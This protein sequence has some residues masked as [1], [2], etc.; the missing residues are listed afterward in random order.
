MASLYNRMKA[1]GLRRE[2]NADG[3]Y[4]VSNNTTR[5]TNTF[6]D[7][8]NRE[9]LLRQIA[10]ERVAQQ[11]AQERQQAAQQIQQANSLR[12]A[13]DYA[14]TQNDTLMNLAMGSVQRRRAQQNVANQAAQFSGQAIQNP[15]QQTANRRNSPHIENLSEQLAKLPQAQIGNTSR[16]SM[17]NMREP[18]IG[19][20]QREI[21]AIQK[22]SADRELA[23]RAARTEQFAQEHP[24]LGMAQSTLYDYVNNAMPLDIAMDKLGGN[25]NYQDYTAA[26]QLSGAALRG[27]QTG[28]REGLGLE[29]GSIAGNLV[30]GAVSTGVGLASNVPLFAAVSSGISAIPAMAKLS[31]LVSNLVRN[32]GA[33]AATTALDEASAAATGNITPSRYAGD[34]ALNAA[35]G[36]AGGAAS[37]GMNRVGANLLKNKGLMYNELARTVLAGLSSSAYS[38]GSVG[39]RQLARELGYQDGQNITPGQLVQDLITSFAFGAINF[40]LGGGAAREF[41]EGRTVNGAERMEENYFKGVSDADLKS[42]YRRMVKTMHPDNGGDA[43]EFAAMSKEYAWRM[44]NSTAGAYTRATQAAATNNQQEYAQAEAEFRDGVAELIPILQSAEPTPEMAA[45]IEV[46]NSV[47]QAPIVQEDTTA[48]S[49]DIT[50]PTTE[51]PAPSTEDQLMQ[52][53]EEAAANQTASEA[54]PD[55]REQMIE[56]APSVP[57]ENNIPGEEITNTA[58]EMPAVEETSAPAFGIEERASVFPDEAAEVYRTHAEGAEDL[59]V[60]DQN[61]HKAYQAGYDGVSLKNL[62]MDDEDFPDFYAENKDAVDEIFRAGY[63]ERVKR[64]NQIPISV[65]ENNGFIQKAETEAQPA[66]PAE[67]KPATKAKKLSVKDI[68]MAVK[69]TLSKKFGNSSISF[70]GEDGRHYVSDGSSVLVF[71][72]QVDGIQTGERNQSFERLFSDAINAALDN[73]D[74]LDISYADIHQALGNLKNSNRVDYEGIKIVSWDGRKLVSFSRTGQIAN[75][76]LFENALRAVQNPTVYYGKDAKTP[77]YIKGDNAEGVVLP[78]NSSDREQFIRQV[79]GTQEGENNGIRRPDSAGGARTGNG[80]SEGSVVPVGRATETSG[81]KGAGEER[82]VPGGSMGSDG[83]T[84]PAV[85]GLQSGRNEGTSESGSGRTGVPEQSRRVAGSGTGGEVQQE[86]SGN[87][88]RETGERDLE[89]DREQHAEGDLGDDLSPQARADVEEGVPESAATTVSERPAETQA[90]VQAERAADIPPKG[91]NFIIPEDGLKLPNGEKARYKSNIAA[92]KTLRTLMA[93]N[94][95]ATPEEQEV[96]SKYVGWGGL[97]NAFSETDTN[98]TKENKQLKE[99]LTD[100]EYKTARGSVL[101]AHYTEVGV[102]RAIYNG[103]KGMGFKGGRILEPAAGV[104]HFAGAMPTDINVQSLTMVELDT[105]TGN[106]AKYLYP[107]ADVRVQGFETANLPNDYMDLAISNVPFGNYAIFDKSYPNSVT[108]AIHNY[109]FAKSLDKVRPGG[110]VCFITSRFTMDARDPAVRKYISDRAD[111]VGAIRLPDTAFKGNAGTEVVTDIL[112]LKKRE[113]GTPYK[114]ESFLNTDYYHQNLNTW[115]QTNEYFQKHP[116]MV[117]GEASAAGTMYRNNSLT[118]KAKPGNLNKQI[119]KA[120]S[121]IKAKID[122]PVR[123]SD[124]DVMRKN[125]TELRKASS[126]TKNGSYVKENGKLYKNDNGA[127][128]EADLKAKEVEVIS[129]SIDMR[130]TARQL[131]NLQM[132]GGTQEEIDRLRRKLNADY[133]AFVKKNGPLNSQANRRV[134]SGDADS[135]F[136]FALE[137]YNADTKTA[138]KADIFSKNTVTPH[139]VVEHVDNM[140]DGLAA[141]INE[142][143]TVDIPLIARVTGKSE[144]QTTRE[145]IDQKLIFKTKDGSLQSAQQYLSGNVRAKL[146]EARALAPIDPDYKKNIDE[147]EKV[148]PKDIEPADISVKPGAT[149]VPPDLYADFA[150]EMLGSNNSGW[151]KTIEVTYVPAAGVYKVSYG[152]AGRYVKGNSYDISEYGTQDKS[153]VQIFEAALN[154]KELKV[155]YPHGKDEKA[156]LNRKAT[157]AVK[158][159]KNQIIQKFQEWMWSDE[160]RVKTYA[161]LYNDMFNN[162]AVPNYDGSKLIIDGLSSKIQLRE[163]QANAVQRII[164]SGGNT[165]LAHGTGSGKTLEMAAAAMKLRQIGAIRKPMFVVPK[166]LLGQWG[167]EFYSYFPNAKILLPGEN[168]FTPK[169]R[170]AFV[171]KITTGD[172]DAV[173]LSYEQFYMVPMSPEA[174]KAFYQNQIDDIIAAQEAARQTEGKKGFTVSALEKK[175]KSLQTKLQKLDSGKRDIDNINFESLGVDSLFVDEAHNFKNLYYTTQLQGVSDLGNQNGSERAFDLYTKV[176]YLQGVN[177][178]RGIVFGT[179]TPVMNSVVEMYSMQRYLQGDLLEQKGINHFDAWVNEFGDVQEIQKMKSGGDGYE[180]RTSL[181]RYRNLGELQQMFRGFADVVTNPP[182]LA[183]KL[184]KLRGG[185]PIVVECEPTDVQRE[186]LKELGERSERVRHSRDL[187]EDNILKIYSDGKKMS[188]TQRMIDS[189][190]PYEDG[191]KILKCVDNVLKEYKSSKSIKGT[192]LVF[193]DTGVIGSNAKDPLPLWQDIKN[194]LIAGGIP[195]KEIAFAQSGMTD[196]QKE[197]M[198]KKMNDGDTRVLIGSTK[199]MGTGLN[200]QKRLYSMHEINAPDRPGDVEQNRGRIVRQ[201]NMNKEVAIYT[202]IT[203]ETFDS[204]QWD[205]LKR[206]GAFIHQ[207]MAGDVAGR[208]VDGDGDFSMSAAEISAIASGNPLIIEQN[209]VSTKIGQLEALESEHTKQVSAARRKLSELPRR[210]EQL[211]NAISNYETDAAH[212]PDLSGD[213]FTLKIG[214]TTF[215]KRTSAGNAIIEEAKKHYNISEETQSFKVGTVGDFDLMVTNHNEGFLKGEGQYPFTI[216]MES[217]DGTIRSLTNAAALPSQ[218]LEIA[219]T[220]L[221]KNQK[222]LVRYE[223]IAKQ[224]FDRADELNQLR[225]REAEIMEILN[226]SNERGV[227]VSEEN[228]VSESRDFESTAAPVEQGISSAKTS[229]KQVP[230]LFKDKNVSWGKVNIDIGGGK[231]DLATDYLK[232]QGVTNLVFDPY[233]RSEA[234][235]SDTLNYLRGGHKADTATCANV[236]NVI[237]EEK[238]RDNVILE[239]AKA[240]KPDGRAYFMVYEGDGS[241]IGKETSSGWQNNRKTATYVREIEKYFNNVKR[242]GKLITATNPVENLPKASW[243]VSPGK[244]IRYSKDM[245]TPHPDQWTAQRVGSTD[246]KVKPLSDIINEIRHSYGINITTGHIRGSGVRGQ[247]NELNKGIRSKIANDLPTI[248]HEMGHYFDDLYGITAGNIPNAAKK[249]L[250]DNLPDEFKQK[251]PKKALPGEGM[252]EYIRRFLQNSETAAIDYPEFTK[253]FFGA[254]TPKERVQLESFAD[255][256]NAYYSLDADSAASSIRLREDGG[257]DLRTPVEKV[258][259][260]GDSAYQQWIDSNYSIKQLGKSVGSNKAYVLATN[261]A[262]SDNMAGNILTGD[263]TDADGRYIGPGLKTALNGVNLRNKREYMAFNEYLVVRH[264]PE[265]LARQ[266]RVFADDRKNNTAWCQIRQN[267]LETQYPAFSE[268]A[269]RLIQFEQDFNRVWGVGYGLIPE[270]VFDKWQ[271]YYPNHVPLNRAMEKGRARGAKR[272]YANQT[273][274]YKRAKG[275]GQDIIAPVDN[276][277]DEVVRVVNTAVRNNV[278]LELRDTALQMGVNATFMEQVPTPLVPKTFDVSGIKGQIQQAIDQSVQGGTLSLKGQQVIDDVLE[279]INDTMLQFERGKAGGNVVTV[280]VNGNP[281]FWKINDP[282]L[283]QSVTTMSG[284]KLEGLLGAY[285]TTTRFLT[286]NITGNN[287]IWSIFSNLPRDFGTLLYY[288]P[289]KNVIDLVAKIGS[290]YLNSTKNHFNMSV[291]PLYAEYL[292]MGGGHTSMYSADINLAKK[293]RKDISGSKLNNMLSMMNPIESL[294]FITDTI[295]QGPRF[296]T[297]RYMR[298][299]GYSTQDA[300]YAAMDVT[301]NFRKAGYKSRQTN[302]VIP[303][304]NAGL[305]GADKFSRYFAADDVQGRSKGKAVASRMAGLVISSAIIASLLYALNNRDKDKRKDYQQLSNYTKNS[306][307]CIPIGNGKYFAIPKPRELAVLTSAMESALE[308]YEGGNVH[309]FDEFADTAANAFLPSIVSDAVIAAV[310][311]PKAIREEEVATVLGTLGKSSI[312]SLGIVG[313]GANLWANMD[314]LGR[315]IVSQSLSGLEK[316]DQYTEKTSKMAKAVGKALN[317]S[318]QQIDYVG[319]NVLGYIWKVPTALFPVGEENVDPTLGIKNSYIKDPQYSTDLVNWAYDHK[320]KTSEKAKSAPDDG[321]KALE[322]KIADNMTSFYGRFIKVEKTDNSRDARQTVLDMIHEYRKAVDNG[323]RTTGEEQVYNLVEH[324]GDTS[325]LPS[326]MQTYVQD[327]DKEKHNLNDAQYVEYQTVYNGRYWAYAEESLSTL[328]NPTTEQQIKAVENAKKLA[329]QDAET[330]MLG[331]IGIISGSS[332]KVSSK[333]QLQFTNEVTRAKEDDGKVSKRELRDIYDVMIDAGLVETEASDL[334]GT[335]IESKSY[336]AYVGSGG[337]VKTYLDASI[338]KE[339]GNQDGVVTYLQKSRLTEDQKLDI[340]INVCGYKESTYDKKMK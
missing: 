73:K 199:T 14:K 327:S 224:T 306:Y 259:D 241:G 175:R 120:F 159:K 146:K 46:L 276:I 158:E 57:V 30:E 105:I 62:M 196:K 29:K 220:D 12:I 177:G 308:R 324:T 280:L 213:K 297:Y 110:L 47:A 323:S 56:E 317:F 70:I 43:A 112:V 18:N 163:H 201:G 140:A 318:P 100:D 291:D 42:A 165:L 157:I 51:T 106:I 129:A 176:R 234:V 319:N 35:A 248:S 168:D 130:D 206:K 252:A 290:G 258:F 117:L 71:N 4:K 6:G 134:I 111:L 256:I 126:K 127:L 314:Y 22:A 254:I 88:V 253:Y 310:D 160:G 169:N 204:R 239:V 132:N 31:P 3:S 125:R 161:P 49:T 260:L 151:R 55:I 186:Y 107:N 86:G 275:G 171:N 5:S 96:L 66:A 216:N 155:Y 115:E 222:E 336:K 83:N 263:L 195:E 304:F 118:Y 229:I 302:A 338:A 93:D 148:V 94:R 26:K 283:L 99:L 194:M 53:A 152:P 238:A 121:T 218:R 272:G 313:I 64:E 203:K 298:E 109:F 284:K 172:W 200:V 244:A 236:L 303:F 78:V 221:D 69:K 208:T 226:P 166:N 277:I 245:G 36:V 316:K 198:Q 270:D 87:A 337:S 16:K 295:E 281:E 326:T 48:P 60:Y 312:G 142:S 184:P 320:D 309:A 180:T 255:E 212:E 266:K 39:T 10:T 170:K 113:S 82:N 97:K 278:M 299:Q 210:I 173:I 67:T 104:G 164:M 38:A 202:Y 90:E 92:I 237:A 233:N 185:A 23:E 19:W 32:A 311:M 2:E 246:V 27:A 247:F 273:S 147:L 286:A 65:A 61:M 183:D 287:P 205:N 321:K 7:A 17:F 193:C 333:S 37:A 80:P 11:M 41:N 108:S 24:L 144:Q 187:K 63:N 141:S 243:E 339:E 21:N 44:A 211:Q 25:R 225:N 85:S 72:N 68:N 13:Q 240:V 332:N 76:E 84:E 331:Q 223:E 271:E 340:W 228:T 262:Y 329:K 89:V 178:G 98:W 135:P 181:A 74:S 267:E 188:Y 133:D 131:L 242:N 81:S 15:V 20:R 58:G 150:A 101:N 231:F 138:T 261:A 114:G 322:A 315:P 103:L 282:L 124:A 227:D 122:Y 34:I 192:Q 123:T 191:G 179:A 230:A 149:W 91:T 128:V 328:K 75:A 251:Y 54:K 219:R 307:Y 50:A 325:I 269:D 214:N 249:E 257:I 294:R 79:W 289:N 285:A 292:A 217:A 334:F 119:E 52:L 153:F 28:T 265:R 162:S 77:I 116:E 232:E 136:V 215:T 154:N 293:V 296:A 264:A 95:Q 59:I 300:F 335:Q 145:L 40:Q 102:I 174:Q 182:G 45:A 8:K 190:L 139:K 197:T 250:V 279:Q 235:N 330:Y 33:M 268:A 9:N 189:S 288:S 167:N 143:G 207:A 156:V 274:P 1:V 301:V 305:Q 209:E 137:N